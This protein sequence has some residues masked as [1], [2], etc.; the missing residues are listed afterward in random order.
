MQEF[1]GTYP[2]T[3]S[4]HYIPRR[5]GWPGGDKKGNTWITGVCYLLG[6]FPLFCHFLFPNKTLLNFFAFPAS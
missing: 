3:G 1:E 2:S 6:K 5:E 4:P